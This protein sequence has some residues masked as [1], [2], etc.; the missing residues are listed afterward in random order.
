MS[1]G[2]TSRFPRLIASALASALLMVGFLGWRVFR[3]ER[4][5]ASAFRA[6]TSIAPTP[7]KPI[8]ASRPL[9]A[10]R[11]REVPRAGVE[12]AADHTSDAE[13]SA[14]PRE[15]AQALF[16]RRRRTLT[17]PA[18]VDTFLDEL[19]ANARMRHAVT[20]TEVQPGL[21]A[22]RQLSGQLTLDEVVQRES[23]FGEEMGR[24]SREYRDGK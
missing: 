18:Q 15:Q 5:S 11:P 14:S 21:M 10:A 2:E 7:P 9:A 23:Q 4:A 17:S 13:P 3:I 8:V 16:E 6:E 1:I 22:I 20:A 12:T 24:L 19:R